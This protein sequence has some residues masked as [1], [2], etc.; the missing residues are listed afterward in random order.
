MSG[1][2]RAWSE[3]YYFLPPY[4]LIKFYTLHTDNTLYTLHTLH[5]K[6]M[7]LHLSLIGRVHTLPHLYHGA[8]ALTDVLPRESLSCT[9]IVYATSH[10]RAVIDALS[11]SQYV[12]AQ[13]TYHGWT[14]R[15]R[16]PRA[17]SAVI[18]YVYHVPAATFLPQVGAPGVY[19]CVGSVAPSAREDITVEALRAAGFRLVEYS[20]E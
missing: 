17:F 20:D 18:G 6:K 14:V 16:Y 5:T 12:T 13:Y 4:N 3:C 9:Q 8:G 10:D 15:E 11:S 19:Y 1:V 2:I 7:L